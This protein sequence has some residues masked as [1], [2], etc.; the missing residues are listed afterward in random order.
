MAPDLP[1]PHV[2]A[3]DP[4]IV[5]ALAALIG[6]VVGGFTSVLTTWQA[7]RIQARALWRRQEHQRRENLYSAFIEEAAECYADAI[8]HDE[9]QMSAF[10]GIYAKIDQMR[11]HS[12]DRVIAAAMEIRGKIV[13]TYLHPNRAF[14]EMR[15]M[16]ADG[17]VD[18]LGKFS[19]A[20]R[21]ELEAMRAERG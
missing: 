16:L 7:Q 19:E 1:R 20:C 10:V 14:L 5:S 15:D 6:A 13:E 11:V 3:M 18:L 17:S 8:Q 9:P 21:I 12:S 2:S 4:N